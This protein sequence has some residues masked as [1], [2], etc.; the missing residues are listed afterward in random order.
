MP[1]LEV[2]RISGESFVHALE[3]RPELHKKLF[4]PL[5]PDT[6]PKAMYSK[7]I[8]LI[9]ET[10]WKR[11]SLVSRADT[12]THELGHHIARKL[13]ASIA[14][15]LGNMLDELDGIV[16]LLLVSKPVRVI[17]WR[18]KINAIRR[19]RNLSFC[20]AGE[21]KISAAQNQV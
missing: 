16:E 20:N 2:K 5:M 21:R 4:L 8:V 7:G 18:A 1:W 17:L 3:R 12:L 13:F 10:R 15:R 11:A 6:A 19:K 9:N 14:D